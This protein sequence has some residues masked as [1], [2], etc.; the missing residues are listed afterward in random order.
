MGNTPHPPHVAVYNKD[1]NVITTGGQTQQVLLAAQGAARSTVGSSD[2]KW[3]VVWFWLWSLHLE[4]DGQRHGRRNSP[5]PV[6]NTALKLPS[7]KCALSVGQ[8]A[9][10]RLEKAISIQ[11]KTVLKSEYCT[12]FVLP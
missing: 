6:K 12:M 9:M 7:L 8:N 10:S 11:N 2:I 4:A 3:Q 1:H 5:G